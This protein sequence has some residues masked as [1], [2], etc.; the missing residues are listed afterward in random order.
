LQTHG[1]VKVSAALKKVSIVSA[2]KVS[3]GVKLQGNLLDLQFN[4]QDFSAAELQQLFQQYQL[5]K[6]FY[7]LP[8]GNLVNLNQGNLAEIDQL[9]HNLQLPAKELF[10]SDQQLGAN[11]AFFLDQYLKSNQVN[12]DLK[13]DEQF[14]QLVKQFEKV[15]QQK[16]DLPTDL[17]ATLRNYQKAGYQWL[18]LLTASHFSGI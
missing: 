12:L 5:K 16:F 14:E 18:R 2:P 15:E 10:I 13:A 4:S 11:R 9:Q 1:I 17:Q 3:V 6:K 7:R 8:N